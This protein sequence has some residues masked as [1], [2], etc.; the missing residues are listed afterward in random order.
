MLIGLDPI[1]G[2][3]VLHALRSMG[4]GDMVVLA[5]A[6]YPAAAVAA[7]TVA[8]R[9][10]RIERPLTEVARAVLSVL[11]LDTFVEDFAARMEVVGDPGA[12]PDV[13]RE[14]QDAIAATGDGRAR[15]QSSSASRSTTSR[16]G[17]SP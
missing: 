1:L 5:D 6:N 3:D 2:A 7:G 16:D 12:V 13:Q 11:P 8:G 15:W 14:V 17:P 9:A 10:L 4:H